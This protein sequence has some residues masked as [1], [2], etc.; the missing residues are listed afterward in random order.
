MATMSSRGQ[1]AL[2]QRLGDAVPAR[3]MKRGFVVDDR[4]VQ[5][6]TWG[7]GIFK[8]SAGSIA[9]SGA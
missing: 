8:R 6:V 2:S 9:G 1:L 5:L 4:L 7:R 3:E